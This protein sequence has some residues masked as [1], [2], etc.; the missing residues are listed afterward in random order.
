MAEN[1]HK[2]KQGIQEADL[3][4]WPEVISDTEKDQWVFQLRREGLKF[5]G[6]YKGG[7]QEEKAHEN[8]KKKISWKCHANSAWGLIQC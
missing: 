6:P 8:N 5:P 3:L 2:E 7:I 4:F 1:S